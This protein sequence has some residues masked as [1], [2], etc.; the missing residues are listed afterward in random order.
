MK[1]VNRSEQGAVNQPRVLFSRCSQKP[2]KK[3]RLSE[4]CIRSW[5]APK[6]DGDNCTQETERKS[7]LSWLMDE[8]NLNF[9][10]AAV[11]GME[12]QSEPTK[13]HF[14]CIDHWEEHSGFR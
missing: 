9:S 10:P 7:S 13:Y 1:T 11:S 2:E 6:S 14:G 3:K 4:I 8:V 12:F 5:R